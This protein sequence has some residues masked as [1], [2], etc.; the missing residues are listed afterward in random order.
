VTTPRRC[1]NF[2]NV[3]YLHRPYLLL[4]VLQTAFSALM[5]LV[6]CQEGHPACEKLSGVMLLMVMRLD[7]GAA[8]ATVTH[9]LLRQ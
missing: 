3:K 9:Y 8:D 6:G 7:Q 2:L 1:G 5:L 4:N